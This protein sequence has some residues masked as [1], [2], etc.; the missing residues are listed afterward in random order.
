MK[1]P[2]LVSFAV[3]ALL[4]AVPATGSA[5]AIAKS[6]GNLRWG[7]SDTEVKR[8][9]KVKIA[10][11]YEAKLKKAKGASKSA[12]EREVASKGKALDQ[13]HVDFTGKS[14]R[15]DRTPIAGEFTYGADESMLTVNDGDSDNY[16]FFIDGRLWK[17]VK[18]Y[19]AS[20]FG[21]KNFN[22]FSGAISKRFG[23]GYKKEGELNA[24]TGKEY[25]W[26]EFLDRQ[27]RL[28]AVDRTSDAGGYALVF[29]EMDTVRQLATLRPNAPRKSKPSRNVSDDD[30]EESHS[31]VATTK[32]P[33]NKRSLFGSEQQE[34]TDSDYES[35][36]KQALADKREHQRRS[37]E[38]EQEM[39]KGKALD[40]LQGVDDDDPLSGMN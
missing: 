5:Q 38:R 30:S 18:L 35:R 9:V 24:G 36:K 25:T 21:G 37:F 16:Y 1:H 32:Q 40:S 10:D 39:K 8:V 12:L 19:P 3:Y 26:L 34:E 6:M 27:N 15:W 28:R 14:S 29:E 13:S 22:K 11:Q 17:W 4:L 7:M 2:H 31:P 23:K 20:A 33:A